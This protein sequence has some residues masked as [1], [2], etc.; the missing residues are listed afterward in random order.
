MFDDASLPP[1]REIIRRHQLRA[2]KALGQNFLLDGNL[3]DKIARL[4]GDFV[5]CG[6]VEIGPG[7]GGLTR[8]LLKTAA[9]EIVAVELDRR[10]V[11]ALQDLQQA[12]G[13]RLRII[14]QDA[15]GLDLTAL[16]VAPRAIVANLPYNIGSLLLV[17]WLSALRRDAGAFTSMT[18]MFQQEVAERITAAPGNKAYGRL[19]VLAQ[20]LCDVRRALELPPSA[21]TPPPKV[22]STVLRFLPRSASSDWPE[23]SRVEKILAAAFQQRR[24]MIRSSLRDYARE[25]EET[26]L[27]PTLRAE[28]VPVEAYLDLARAG[29]RLPSSNA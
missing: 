9:R 27:D 23:F 12:A 29:A 19:S 7:P 11:E 6:I 26:G 20:W 21:F 16:L 5:G 1:L 28:D 8:S 17:Q 4:A 15:L 14:R 2:E 24:K 22:N 25:V 10:A 3:T 13:G 18:L